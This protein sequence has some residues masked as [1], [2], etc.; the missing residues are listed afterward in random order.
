MSLSPLETVS[1]CTAEDVIKSLIYKDKSGR[2][3]VHAKECSKESC[4]CP[5]RLAAGTVDS[6]LGKLRAIF[7]TM[8]RLNDSNPV[9]H[10]RVKEYVKFVREEQAGVGVLPSQ[11]V[12]QFF[13][14]FSK[15]VDYLRNR[16]QNSTGLSIS[17]KYILVRDTVFLVVALPGIVRRI[18]AGFNRIRFSY[19]K[20]G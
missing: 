9:A 20:T 11:A 18:W 6:M 12:P 2:T 13:T 15:L 5:N 19:L 17:D 14:K 4:Q 1:S 8:G 16:I 3:I 7:N 10:P